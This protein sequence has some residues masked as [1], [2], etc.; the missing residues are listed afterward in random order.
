MV[1]FSVSLV[2]LTLLGAALCS[3]WTWDW[4]GLARATRLQGS[5]P[6]G[7]LHQTGPSPS[8][9][10]WAEGGSQV[11]FISDWFERRL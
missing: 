7:P 2:A 8:P 5:Q 1:N 4:G 9:T 3:E 11:L 6:G 10:R